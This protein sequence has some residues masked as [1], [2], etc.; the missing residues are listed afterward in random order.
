MIV[1]PGQRNRLMQKLRAET[2]IRRKNGICGRAEGRNE[3][4]GNKEERSLGTPSPDPWDLSRG[5]QSQCIKF[6]A[7]AQSAPNPSLVLAPE[8]ALSLL[9]SVG[10]RWQAR[11]V[12]NC[13]R[14]WSAEADRK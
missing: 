10:L 7:G 3:L 14:Q 2:C 4:R 5:C 13:A 1:T 9:P 6:A 12:R 11:Q 8:S